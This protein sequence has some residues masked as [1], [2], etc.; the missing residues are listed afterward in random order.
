[1]SSESDPLLSNSHEK[2]SLHHEDQKHLQMTPSSRASKLSFSHLI[3]FITPLLGILFLFYFWCNPI[4]HDSRPDSELSIAERVDKILTN[5][6]LIDGHND[7]AILIRFLHGNHIYDKNFTGPFENG[8]LLGHVDLPRLRHG[9]VGGTFWSAWVACPKNGTDF[10]DDNYVEAVKTTLSQIDLL[11]RLRSAYPSVFSDPH[12][13]GTSALLAFTD[14][15][16]LISPLAI[17][18][19]HQIGNSVANLRLFYSLGVRYATLTH[20]CHNAFADAALIETP[21]DSVITAPPHW[22]GV[23]EM[24]ELLVKEMNRLGMLVDLSHVSKDTMLDVLGGRPEKWHGSIAPAMFSHSSAFTICPHPRNVPDDV[25]KLV[26][27]TNSVV[28]INFNPGFVSCVASNSSSGVPDFY[29]QNSTLQHVVSHVKYIGDLIGYDYVGIGSDF[30]GI[31]ETPEG[32]DDVSK[33]PDL[34]AEMLHRGISDKDAAKVIGGNILRVWR[35][36]DSVAAKM[37]K[38][39]VQ[40]MED[41]I[42]V[43]SDMLIFS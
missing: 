19:L 24:G 7:L 1:M 11:H 14:Q 28:M 22:G 41:D 21:D 10:S 40:P 12:L 2:T 29:P 31:F 23:S 38:D 26:R 17:E 34:V 36:V 5:T 37:Q 42:P 16:Q 8:G 43:G 32:L 4:S 9:K 15:D 20:N 27:K 13:N 6:P 18:G 35:D 33:F 39:G 3:I 25:L 30:D